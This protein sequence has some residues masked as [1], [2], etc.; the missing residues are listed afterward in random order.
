[1]K[2]LALAAVML[3]GCVETKPETPAPQRVYDM[4]NPAEWCMAAAEAL[5]NPWI[6]DFRK[7][8]L[9]EMMRNRGC[10]N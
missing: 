9:L 3:T 4:N 6:D 1:M 5:G 7:M 2:R 10:L 8:A